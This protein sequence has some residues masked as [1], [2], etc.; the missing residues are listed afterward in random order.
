MA[1]SKI[2]QYRLEFAVEGFA[3]PTR[4]HVMGIWV[5]PT[6]N[7]PTGSPP[8]DID[9]QLKGGGTKNLQEVADQF[10]SFVRQQ[11][12]TAITLGSFTL[13]RQAT[14]FSRDFVSAGVATTTV[15]GLGAITVAHQQTM[16]FRHANGGIGKLV[17]LESNATGSTRSA[18]SV[19]ASGS[20]RE[21]LAA[22]LLSADSPMIALDNSFAVAPLRLS[23]GENEAIWRKVYRQ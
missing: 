23:L 9:I 17:L 21:R 14:E 13:W 19:N 6:T 1:N 15:A 22:Y 12:S 5:A 16:T 8:T 20:P 4:S 7:P 3:S 2:G 10:L 11:Y 18:L